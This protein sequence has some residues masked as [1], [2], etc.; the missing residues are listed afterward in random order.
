MSQQA[1]EDFAPDR[2]RVA[3][4][5][6]LRPAEPSGYAATTAGAHWRGKIL[7][8]RQISDEASISTT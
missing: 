3:D 4:A 5:D 2:A 8:A 6:A 1:N 7:A